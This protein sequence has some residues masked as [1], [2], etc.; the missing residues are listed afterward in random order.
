MS[1]EREIDLDSA[2]QG[3]EGVNDEREMLHD[4]IDAASDQDQ[5]TYVRW[6][7]KRICAIVPVE[8]AETF[9]KKIEEVM[10]ALS[11]RMNGS[12]EEA[13][14]CKLVG[15]AMHEVNAIIFRPRADL[16]HA[17]WAGS[18]Q[19][20]HRAFLDTL[21]SNERLSSLRARGYPGESVRA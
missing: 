5:I 19:A 20:G 2:R 21:A 8:V 9:T 10:D 1:E 11:K 13:P 18:L 15:P 12:W 3:Y 7:G 14:D 17:H 16:P 4:A 6:D